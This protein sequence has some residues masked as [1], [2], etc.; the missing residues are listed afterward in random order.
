VRLAAGA[1]ALAQRLPRRGTSGAA[2]VGAG[3][4]AAFLLG[5]PV[6]AV[7]APA[8]G[9]SA[10]PIAV[11][12]DTGA[13]VTLARPAER[14]V[15]LSPHIVEN[16]YAVGAGERIVGAVD[17]SDHPP[18]ARQLPRIGSFDRFDVERV[19]A[20]APD[21][22]I[23]WESGNNRTQLA[24][25]QA[26]GLTI[27]RSQPDTLADV[28]GELARFGALTGKDADGEAA[29]RRFRERL[30]A[31]RDRY[32]SRPPVRVFYQ[33][34]DAPLMTVGRRQIITDAIALC[35][36]DN[37]FGHLWPMAPQVSVEAVL[38]ADPE[39]MVAGGMGEVRRDWLES[40]RRWRQLTAVARDNLFFVPADWLQ[41]H[42]PRLLDG[43]AELCR[44]LETARARR[45]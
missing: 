36:G 44:H 41:R 9:H 29:A 13:T 15:A 35:G 6:S 31:L 23:G 11:T 10:T 18:A 22:V 21:L 27:Y 30:A 4:V 42:T 7:A 16:L 45:P 12:D 14:I 3:L 2:S 43:A 20:L 19:L 37:V 8:R 39:A 38:A 17:F 32:G 28:A 26:L 1:G 24:Q 40:W 33:I 25:L 34:W 5:V